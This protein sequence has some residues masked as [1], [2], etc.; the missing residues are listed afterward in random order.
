VGITVREITP[1]IRI[2]LSIDESVQGVLIYRVK[3]GSPAQLS[4]LGRGFIIQSIGDSPVQ[5]I[6]EFKE[7]VKIIEEKKPKEIL[8]L[9]R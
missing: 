6:G 8:S 7:M 4:R 2:A 9:Q 1:D 3:S 5:S